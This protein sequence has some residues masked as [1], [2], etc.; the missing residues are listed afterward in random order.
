MTDE[1]KLKEALSKTT[2]GQIEVLRDAIHDLFKLI[3]KD[4]YKYNWAATL[5][6]IVIKKIE[7]LGH[8]LPSLKY[9]KFIEN[10][11]TI[12]YLIIALTITL[13][14]IFKMQLI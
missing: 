12:L 6:N 13:F 14:E 3:Y 5:F 4:I 11:L 2:L 10:T 8:K 7:K 1:Q 9:L